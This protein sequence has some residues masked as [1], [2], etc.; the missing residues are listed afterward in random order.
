MGTGTSLR[1]LMAGRTA[2][3]MTRIVG[4]SGG[5]MQAISA[6]SRCTEAAFRLRL[7]RASVEMDYNLL[8]MEKFDD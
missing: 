8:G 5:A 2:S 4:S 1:D 7:T 3:Y 6:A